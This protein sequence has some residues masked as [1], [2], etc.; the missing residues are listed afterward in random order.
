[1]HYLQEEIGAPNVQV[2]NLSASSAKFMVAPL[3][4]GY[5]MTL[6][7]SYRRILLSSIPGAAITSVKIDGIKHE[8][9]TVSGLY[10]TVLD[11]IL[12]LKEI[13]V[14]S[15]LDGKATATINKKGKGEVL[16]SD[17]KLPEGVEIVNPDAYITSISEDKH[18][19]VAEIVIEKGFGYSPATEREFEDKELIGVD[20]VFSPIKQVSWDVSNMRVGQRTDLDKLE[21][22]L[23]TDGSIDP[24]DA[25]RYAANLGKYYFTLFDMSMDKEIEEMVKTALVGSPIAPQE[26]ESD[27]SYTPIEILSLSPRTLNALINGG[28]DSVEKL[29]NS[30]KKQLGDLKGFGKKAMDEI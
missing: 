11:I 12:N 22:T 10:D 15:H 9:E 7:N 13:V 24:E 28:I 26:E 3:P 14:V 2:E 17:I 6:G 4:P 5:G 8:F 23:D 16:A 18:H 21:I 1:M 25:L 30:T 27:E 19:F 20:A 29:E